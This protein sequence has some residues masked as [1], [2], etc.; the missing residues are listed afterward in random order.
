MGNKEA[1]HPQAFLLEI[2]SNG[3]TLSWNTLYPWLFDSNTFQS[4]GEFQQ[5]V[6]FERKLIVINGLQVQGNTVIILQG[7]CSRLSSKE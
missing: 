1:D 5:M 2:V 3:S 6:F 4:N 7:L